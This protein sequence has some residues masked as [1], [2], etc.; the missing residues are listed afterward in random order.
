MYQ[1]TAFGN[2]KTEFAEAHIHDVH[3][4]EYLAWTPM[5][6]LIVL[7]GLVPSLIFRVTDGPVQKVTSAFATAPASA[8]TSAAP[9]GQP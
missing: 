5:L 6:V 8:T 7:L 2:P 1:R 4:P 3:L 9:P